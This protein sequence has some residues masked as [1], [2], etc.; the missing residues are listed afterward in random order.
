MTGLNV[1]VC[2]P[3]ESQRSSQTS[4]DDKNSKSDVAK[5]S[6][7]PDA[8]KKNILVGRNSELVGRKF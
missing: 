5:N 2:R 8:V 6:H 7:Q 1:D 4:N 3:D